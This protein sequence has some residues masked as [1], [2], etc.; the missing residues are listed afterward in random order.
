M[1]SFRLSKF[2]IAFIFALIA[3]IS[4]Q[5][6]VSAAAQTVPTRTPTP[7]PGEPPDDEDPPP[8]DEDPPPPGGSNPTAVPTSTSQPLATR[9]ASGA[10]ATPSTANTFLPTAAACS[11]DPT[12]QSLSAG[13]NVRSGPGTDYDLVSRLRHLEVRPI[14]GRAENA[15][16][17]QIRL[18]DGTNGWVADS[19]VAVSGYTGAVPTVD[20]PEL[21]N[22]N[23]PTPGAPWTPTPVP[24]CTP[25]PTGTATPTSS[26]T[27]RASA[28]PS[29]VAG[30]EPQTG[31]MA[32]TS[33][34]PEPTA[35]EETMETPEV[36]PTEPVATV[37]PAPLPGEESGDTDGGFP[38]LPVAGIGL[39]VAAAV[40]FVVRRGAN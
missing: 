19:V 29:G 30:D 2:F 40:I 11:M 23:T 3:V 16:W 37:T 17:W 34:T 39:I 7:P 18:E 33:R 24:S 12:I 6:V 10:Q 31:I 20:P 9:E 38:W 5:T 4:L 26:A 35:T 21:P 28:T 8:D 25:Q 36:E 13:V 27:R 15:P 32:E 1:S 22:G 14:I